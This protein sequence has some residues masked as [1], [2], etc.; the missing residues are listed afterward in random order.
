MHKLAS[1]VFV[2]SL[3]IL[4]TTGPARAEATLDELAQT[5]T[6]A[7]WTFQEF[8]NDPTMGWF[9]DNLYR[10]KGILIMPLLV[11]GGFFVGAYGGHGVLLAQNES[12]EWS[13]PAF[14]NLAAA[15]FGLQAGAA[16]GQALLMIMSE[17]GLESFMANK[18]RLGTEAS[19][20]AG[21]VGVG[22]KA[23]LFDIYEFSR[24]K[25]LFAGLTIEG[26]GVVFDGPDNRTYYGQSEITPREILIERKYQNAQADP[27]IA[28]VAKAARAQP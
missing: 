21:P 10:A 8:H 19:I 23:E 24:I 11:K 13:Y 20:G 12:G 28:E 14:Y 17:Q 16:G 6:K 26:G 25:G 27:L 1:L 18:V 2:L 3:T 15:T 9:R 7:Q 5:V 22:A 4:L